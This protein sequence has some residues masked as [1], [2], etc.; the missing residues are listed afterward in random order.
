VDL[1]QV[2]RYTLALI[3]AVTTWGASA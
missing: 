1:H 2:R 3:E